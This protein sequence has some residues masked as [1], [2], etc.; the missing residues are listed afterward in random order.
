[1]STGSGDARFVYA[2]P[3]HWCLHGL[4]L[5]EMT[6][7][8]EPV[9]SRALCDIAMHCPGADLQRAATTLIR[10][11]A[12]RDDDG[13]PSSTAGTQKDRLDDV[14]QAISA[15]SSPI[16]AAFLSALFAQCAGA[17]GH[18]SLAWPCVARAISGLDRMRPHSDRQRYERVYLYTALVRAG[19]GPLGDGPHDTLTQTAARAARHLTTIEDPFYRMRATALLAGVLA[20]RGDALEVE[21]LFHPLGPQLRAARERPADPVHAGPDYALFCLCLAITASAMAGR[22]DWLQRDTDW[23]AHADVLLDEVGPRS[24]P[25][26]GLFY[27]IAMVSIGRLDPS[28]AATVALFTRAMREYLDVADGHSV[29]DYLRCTYLV[30]WGC[31]LGQRA[32]LDPRL[33]ELLRRTLASDAAWQAEGQPETSYSSGYTVMAYALTVAGLPELDLG[34]PLHAL[35]GDLK[36]RLGAHA[37]PRSCALRLTAALSLHAL[38]HARA[39]AP[40]GDARAG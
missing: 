5:G 21:A 20:E 37:A 4:G 22:S 40:E 12:F 34:R 9:A 24:R 17:A 1:M 25:S 39:A 26:M 16:E 35:A 11:T 14:C 7:P 18:P 15:L 27:T 31:L 28:H 3:W 30:H 8:G 33:F 13:E 10:A 2:T 23:I 32:Q 29:D 36:S 38:A 6:L 19:A